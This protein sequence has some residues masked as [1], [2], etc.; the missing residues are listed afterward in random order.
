MNPSPP[1]KKGPRLAA[2]GPKETM[3]FGFLIVTGKSTG[4]QLYQSKNGGTA[5]ELTN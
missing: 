3:S 2:V 4:S 1:E 5:S